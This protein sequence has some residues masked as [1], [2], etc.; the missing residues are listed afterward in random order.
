[1]HGV[2]STFFHQPHRRFQSLI[3]GLVGAKRQGGDHHGI[4]GSIAHGL[5]VIDHFINADGNC[6]GT[7]VAHRPNRIT[8]QNDVHACLVYERSYGKIIGREESDLLAASL[9][10]Q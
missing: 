2:G 3:I 7:A 9:L 8:H 1:M 5:G 10:P 6:F 4:T